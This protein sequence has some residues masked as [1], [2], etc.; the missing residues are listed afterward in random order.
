MEN[1]IPMI[2]SIFSG[3]AGITASIILTFVKYNPLI[4]I[5]TYFKIKILKYNMDEN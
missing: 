3:I 2:I 5:L 1:Y 4:K